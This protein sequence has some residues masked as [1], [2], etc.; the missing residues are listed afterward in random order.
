MTTTVY[1]YS[2]LGEDERKS[3]EPPTDIDIACIYDGD[4]SC[5]RVECSGTDVQ[6]AR[7]LVGDG[8]AD[9]YLCQW[10]PLSDAVV[11]QQE[12]DSLPYHSFSS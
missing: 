2:M 11:K 3:A 7:L 5:I 12:Y 10:V 4:L 1:I 8:E 6:I 9:D